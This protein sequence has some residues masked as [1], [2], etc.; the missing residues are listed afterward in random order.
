MVYAGPR[1][2]ADLGFYLEELRGL[3]EA[4]GAEVVGEIVQY[5]PQGDPRGYLGQGKLEEA[6]QDAAE[7]GAGLIVAAAALS[8]RQEREI[9][10]RTA[11]RVVDRTALILDIFAQRALS[12]EGK[13]QVE[14]AQLS[15]LLP[16][17]RRQ[18][19]S[20]S[21]LGGGIGTRGPGES[22]LE[23]DRRRLRARIAELER[24]LGAV[25]RQR[26]V[27][28]QERSALPRIA[29][30]GYTNAGK[31]TLLRALTAGGSGGEDRLFATLDPLTRRLDLPG[32][33]EALLTDTVGFVQELPTELVAAFRATPEETVFADLLLHVVDASQ[34]DWARQSDAVQA[35]LAAIGAGQVPQVEVFNKIDRL[36]AAQ[37]AELPGIAVS[38]TGGTGLDQLRE[39]IA[40]R[41]RLRRVRR[42]FRI[43]LS[44]GDILAQVHAHGE[45]LREEAEAEAVEVEVW[46]DGSWAGRIEAELH[47]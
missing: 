9:E 13:L 8:S 28:R 6:A 5:L 26:A 21:R 39:A 24:R 25:G 30:V 40:Q 17:L 3:C 38:A 22:K 37:A 2:A 33:H 1:R 36:P 10:R 14:L 46:L 47:G 27:S 7:C 31:S 15:Y 19:G 34:P 16:R 23:T 45:V 4:A 44:R 11:L 43:P 20:L 29:L 18:A 41:L 12:Q 35:T 42:S 32:R